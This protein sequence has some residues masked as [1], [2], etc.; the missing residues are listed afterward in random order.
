MLATGEGEV[1]AQVQG[2][3]DEGARRVGGG[4]ARVAQDEG[5]GGGVVGGYDWWGGVLVISLTCR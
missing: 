4:G 1:R 3:G 5:E 2:V